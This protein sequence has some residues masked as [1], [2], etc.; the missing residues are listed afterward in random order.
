MTE[1]QIYIDALI[2]LMREISEASYC[3]GWLIGLEYALWP[4]AQAG[5]SAECGGWLISVDEVEE[6][7]FLSD[8]IGGW[9][10]WPESEQEEC[11]V[12][13]ETWQKTYAAYVGRHGA[14]CL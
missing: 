4:I 12:D 8:K 11:F 5:Q 7:K 2:H 13:M 9:I 1:Q 10:W 3:A 6:L 14:P